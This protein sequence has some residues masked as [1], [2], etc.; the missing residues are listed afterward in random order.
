MR[1]FG[2]YAGLALGFVIVANFATGGYAIL[3]RVMNTLKEVNEKCYD[4]TGLLTVCKYHRHA[5]KRGNSDDAACLIP[6][7]HVPETGSFQLVLDNEGFPGMPGAL[8]L[9]TKV[10]SVPNQIYTRVRGKFRRVRL[11]GFG[12]KLNEY[13]CSRDSTTAI[14]GFKPQ[15]NGGPARPDYRIHTEPGLPGKLAMGTI[16]T[17][18]GLTGSQKGKYLELMISKMSRLTISCLSID[19][20][21]LV[22][23]RGFGNEGPNNAPEPGP[24]LL[25]EFEQ[26]YYQLN[27]AAGT[28]GQEEIGLSEDP[29]AEIAE[30]SNQDDSQFE[31]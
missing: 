11:S 8:M 3:A 20:N 12:A 2:M 14:F 27:L 6:V 23:R 25:T 13:Q 31:K 18:R 5:H 10:N 28:G 19:W 30:E 9:R 16:K 17:V 22:Y 4:A 15:E 26:S 21:E 29:P 7:N 1:G 24:Y